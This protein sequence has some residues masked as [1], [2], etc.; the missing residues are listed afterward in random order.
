MLFGHISNGN[1][2]AEIRGTIL[3]T[4]SQPEN[5]LLRLMVRPGGVGTRDQPLSFGGG[6]ASTFVLFETDSHLI[7]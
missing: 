6:L 3:S 4:E 1:E 7:C 2:S 5:V